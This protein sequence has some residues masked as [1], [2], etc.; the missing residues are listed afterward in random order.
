MFG[1]PQAA[2]YSKEFY[3]KRTIFA[4]AAVLMMLTGCIM[5]PFSSSATLSVSYSPN[6]ADYPEY[7]SQDGYTWDASITIKET[8][9]VGVTLGNYGPNNCACVSVIYYNGSEVDRWYVY[10]DEV[11]SW[12]GSL[13]IDA[14]GDL[15][16]S[17]TFSTGNYS[18]A[19]F[20]ETYYGMD[21]NG[22]V[23]SSKGTLY[24]N[25]SSKKAE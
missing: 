15:H 2:R 9:G 13:R 11:E 20:E 1:R 19:V 7:Y 10:A 18:E 5:L 16:Q 23:V 4:A 6:P 8:S 17:A 24:L 12:F 3:M 21:D 22:N 25:N 14:Y